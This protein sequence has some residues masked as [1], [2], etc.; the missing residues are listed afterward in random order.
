MCKQSEQFKEKILHLQ[1]IK[2]INVH[3][4]HVWKKKFLKV[5][6]HMEI[7]IKKGSETLKT[8]SIL[9]I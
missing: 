9:S 2:K 8:V 5:Y 1:A 6:Y 3:P 7:T 4:K